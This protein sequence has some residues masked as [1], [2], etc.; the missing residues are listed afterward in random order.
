MK[1]GFKKPISWNKYRSEMT[2][3]RKNNNLDYL[4]DPTFRNISSLFA[5]SFKNGD[6]DPTRSSFYEY[7]IPLLEIKLSK[8]QETMIIQ[9]KT[10]YIVCTIKSIINLLVLIYQDKQIR[11]FLN[12]LI[13]QMMVQ[14]KI[15]VQRCF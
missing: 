4:I 14:M 11:L 8:Y 15:M 13:L 7:Y 12:I 10:Y 9:Q 3:Q 2:T 5:F 6:D 1:Q